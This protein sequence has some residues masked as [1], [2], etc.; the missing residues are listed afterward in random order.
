MLRLNLTG[1]RFDRLVAIAPAGKNPAGRV[2]WRFQCDCGE[3]TLRDGTSI[4]TGKTRSCGCLGREATS[5]RSKTHGETGSPT[6][7]VWNQMRRRCREKVGYAD[8]GI[9][10][11]ERWE[12]YANFLADM[13]EKPSGMQLDRE[14]ND[15]GYSPD[16]C[17]W[18]TPMENCNNR[19]DN[20]RIEIN[21]VTRTA[22]EWSRLS[23]IQS[24]TIRY[25]YNKG[26]APELILRSV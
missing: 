9:T 2:L 1:Q 11:C 14:D 18:A 17:R 12:M 22:A 13:G 20:F 7:N 10:V 19:R 8:R 25:R 16:N 26:W 15:Q 21:G 4:K 24:Q 6:H 23:G 5:T 3:E